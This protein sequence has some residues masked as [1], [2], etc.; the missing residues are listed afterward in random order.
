[1]QKK[2]KNDSSDHDG[3]VVGQKESD[4]TMLTLIRASDEKAGGKGGRGD[5]RRLSG[6]EGGGEPTLDTPYECHMKLQLS[7]LDPDGLEV[8]LFTQNYTNFQHG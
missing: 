8:F 1:M 6:R 7:L 2:K 3:D 5:H 4:F